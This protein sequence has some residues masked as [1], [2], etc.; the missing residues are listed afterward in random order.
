MIKF[1]KPEWQLIPHDPEIV[2]SLISSLN[3]HPVTAI[4]LANRGIFSKQEALSFLS[5]SLGKIRHPFSIKDLPR[6][7]DRVIH[8]L[9]AKEKILIFG[10]YDADGITSTVILLEFLRDLGADVDFY[11]PHRT[12]EGYGLKPGHIPEVAVTGAVDLIITVDCGSDSHEAV[13]K[14]NAAGID[15]IITD[16]HTISS[17]MPQAHAVVNPKR[18]DCSSG[19]D[20]LAGVGVVYYLMMGIRKTLREKG[21]FQSHPEPNL[22]QYCDLVALGTVADI[23]PLTAEN[24][25]FTRTGLELMGRSE[26]IGLKTLMVSANITDH[27]VDTDDVAF[28]L[29]P[30]LNAAGRIGHARESI[31]LLTASDRERAA[32]ISETLSDYNAYRKKI[33]DETFKDI[34]MTIERNPDLLDRKSMVFHDPEWHEGILG[35][36]ASRL[37]RK[38]V[39]PVVLVATKNGVGRGSARSIPGFDLYRGLKQCSTLLEGYGGHTLAAGLSIKTGR[40][41]DFV[42]RFESVVSEVT[43][44]DDFMDPVFIDHELPFSLITP[45]LLDEFSRLMPFGKENPEPLFLS[46]DVKVVQSHILGKNHRRMVL[47]Q[48][49]DMSNTV[50]SAIHFNIDRQSPKP[51]HLTHILYRLRYNRYNGRKS[52]QLVIE[53]I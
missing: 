17:D 2:Q 6:A 43:R 15:V 7:V 50:L 12:R 26:R 19:L 14:A 24:R 27:H 16:H 33:E 41:P 49:S 22:K 8:A 23:V 52:I 46:R 5:P 45:K 39:K 11:I 51:R 35:I 47:K 40:L 53:D 34:L 3:C 21:F 44:P 18:P 42:S 1:M 38:F 10:D 9:S 20:H 37:V 48:E 28:R 36:V 4:I 32:H 13:I 31:Q 30:R 29:A 25:A